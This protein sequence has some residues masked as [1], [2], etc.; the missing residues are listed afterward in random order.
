MALYLGKDKIAGFSTDS[1]IGDTLPIGTIVE[2]NGTE[3]PV[4]WELVEDSSPII[5]Y[6]TDD[7]ETI[8]NKITEAIQVTY[9]ED[10]SLESAAY[11]N[12]LFFRDKNCSKLLEANFIYPSSQDDAGQINGWQIIFNTFLCMGLFGGNYFYSRPVSVSYIDGEYS[13]TI[14]DASSM[15]I[16]SIADD[17]E[18]IDSDYALSAT[19]GNVLNEKITTL[20]T[21]SATKTEL[22]DNDLFLIKKASN[23]S[24]Q[25]AFALQSSNYDQILTDFDGKVGFLLIDADQVMVGGINTY[26][27]TLVE[28][29]CKVPYGY[30]EDY[31]ELS[32][33][34]DAFNTHYYCT[35]TNTSGA[36]VEASYRHVLDVDNTTQEP[37]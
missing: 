10:G 28:V 22:T 9:T 1:R 4:N 23:Y 8:Y 37:T 3:V 5:I 29:S 31:R 19:Q 36:W 32:F 35:V 2:Y 24:T 27:G 20:E 6:D 15:P 14:E 34:W 11:I 21:N 12:S 18:T 25:S 26:K 30:S 17:L 13:L 7:A 16:V 33:A